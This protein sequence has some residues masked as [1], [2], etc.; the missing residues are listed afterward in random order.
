MHFDYVLRPGKATSS[1]A[2]KLLEVVGLATVADV[3]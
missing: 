1:N 2:L 3:T